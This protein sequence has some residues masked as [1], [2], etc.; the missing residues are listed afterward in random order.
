MISSSYNLS[1]EDNNPLDVL[2]DLSKSKKWELVRE[3]EDLLIID[4][5]GDQQNYKLF[6]E[7]QEEFQSLQV[8]CLI[9]LTLEETQIPAA[10]QLI[11][12][13][14]ENL[15]LGS[16]NISKLQ[17]VFNYAMM[18]QAVP[19]TMSI[20][21]ILDLLDIMV[22]E[23][24]RFYTTFELLSNGDVRTRDVLSAAMFETVGEA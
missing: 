19:D 15:W 5:I 6:I 9:N 21:M 24:D 22:A 11:L 7:W 8:S 2:Q 14:N 1:V 12:E 23:C 13:I 16:F 20:P 17:P 3:N 18:L 10:A 4:F